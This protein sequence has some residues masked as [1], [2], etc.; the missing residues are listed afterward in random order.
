MFEGQN[1]FQ[2][3]ILGLNY[4]SNPHKVKS[5]IFLFSTHIANK[6]AIDSQQSI[7]RPGM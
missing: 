5:Y 3:N 2:N 6:A 7:T 1:G 4:V